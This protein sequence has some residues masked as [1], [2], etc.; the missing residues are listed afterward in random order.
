MARIFLGTNDIASQLA[1]FRAGFEAMGHEVFVASRVIPGG[2]NTTRADVNLTPGF[3]QYLPKKLKRW[4]SFLRWPWV[5]RRTLREAMDTCDVFLF[6]ALTFYMD[7]RDLAMLKRA[8]KKIIGVFIGSDIRWPPAARQEFDHYGLSPIPEYLPGWVK[9]VPRWHLN[10][11]LRYARMMER[12]ADLVVAGAPS[13][14]LL[15][16][17]YLNFQHMLDLTRLV[18]PTPQR[19]TRPKVIHAPTN[20]Q[21]K[22]TPFV[23][24]AF[25]TLK[26]RGVDFEPILVQGIP[27][28]Q[29]LKLYADADILVCQLNCPGGGK[30]ARECLAS[31]TVVLTNHDPRY[32]MRWPGE[33]PLVHADRDNITEV[34]G[35]LISNYDHRCGLAEAGV[36]YAKQYLDRTAVCRAYLSTMQSGDESDLTRPTFFRDH[37]QPEPDRLDI[38]NRWTR[39]VTDCDWYRRHIEPG[40][41]AGLVFPEPRS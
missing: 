5:T 1:D 10:R 30:Q 31:G 4:G 9:R 12:Y 2:I 6:Q 39:T 26:Q 24:Q 11:Q 35:Q 23:L 3:V 16:R 21:F 28:H 32:P 41:R 19:R 14:Q 17:P 20:P 37:Y 33:I 13:A 40:E 27:N 34:L 22:G 7:H 29:V 18:E 25:E 36:A 8:N 15:M 38:Y